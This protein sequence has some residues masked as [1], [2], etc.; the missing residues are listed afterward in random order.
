MLEKVASPPL[1][2][3][4]A[5]S[6]WNTI[7]AGVFSRNPPSTSNMKS[8]YSPPAREAITSRKQFFFPAVGRGKDI[9]YPSQRVCSNNNNNSKIIRNNHHHLQR[10]PWCVSWIFFFFF[11]NSPHCTPHTLIKGS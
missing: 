4:S 3:T 1:V 6:L 10:I 11:I 9:L 7:S 5:F 2:A 8:I